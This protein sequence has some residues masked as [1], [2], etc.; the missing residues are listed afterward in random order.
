[1][2]IILY[3]RSYNSLTSQVKNSQ[4]KLTNNLTLGLASVVNTGAII[5]TGSGSGSGASDASVNYIYNNFATK[6]YVDNA[7]SNVNIDLSAVQT[8]IV[9]SGNTT[10]NL[11]APNKW[12]SST[13]TKDLYV[14]QNTIRIGQAAISSDGS[15]VT[16]P[17]GSKIGGINPGTIVIKGSFALT[18]SLP[19]T[20]AVGDGY[21]IGG[22]LWVASKTNS[23]IA[24][25]WT[26]VGAFE[27]PMGPTGPTGPTGLTGSQG[28]IGPT[29]PQGPVGTFNGNSTVLSV[30]DINASGSA[31][32]SGT[33]TENGTALNAKYAGF[34]YVDGSFNNIRT[35]YA[36]KSAVDS[37][38]NGYATKT[39]VDN[40]LVTV[41]TDY[42]SYV[43]A[44]INGLI[45]SAPGTLDTLNEIAN[46]IGTDA[47]FSV[48]ILNKI[49][50][51]DA[52]INNI[53]TNYT[54]NTKFDS[55]IN[56]LQ[57]QINSVSAS[58]LSQAYV[59]GSLN[60]IRTNYATKNYVDTS[61]NTALTSYATKSYVDGSLNNIRSNYATTA[62]LAGYI[63]QGTTTDVSI[64]GNVQLGGGGKFVAVNKVPGSTYALDVSGQTLL[65]GNVAVYKGSSDPLY[66]YLDMS[67]VN[68]NIFSV[69][70]KFNSS[71][72]A[73]PTPTFNCT[74]GTVFDLSGVAANITSMTFTNVPA[75]LNQSVSLTVMLR[76]TAG[77]LVFTGTAITINSLG[78][79]TFLKPDATAFTTPS[80][81]K[82]VIYQ[83]VILW[84]SLTAPVVLAYQS[85]L[86]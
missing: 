59:D 52:S 32:V 48:T 40:S 39:Y 29:G 53:R 16:L 64:N 85:A 37:S 11:G 78:L 24:D 13:Y 69:A 4:L 45:N 70:E 76:Q 79:I 6:T 17:T 33:I 74:Q 5:A 15:S 46:A 57:S 56:N 84:V 7:V 81:A 67:G 62:S 18:S 27:G 25:G 28:S 23:T 8:N 1:M 58:S 9:P 30:V 38:L 82:I 12:F 20:N 73:S 43:D 2:Y 10:I 49:A 19:T 34:S 54:T 80:G 77:N 51:S 68:L 26:N 47:S 42:R 61:L 71:V 41:R 14:S 75:T 3:M 50:S 83:F 86:G 21:I 55:S 65:T 63:G 72:Y 60:D 44:Q 35:N 22:N 31:S 66:S 36:L